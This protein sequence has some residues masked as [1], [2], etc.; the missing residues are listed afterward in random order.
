MIRNKKEEFI[1][2]LTKKTRGDI[3]EWEALSTGKYSGYIF[4]SSRVIKL[5]KTEY[6]DKDILLVEKK[7]PVYNEDYEEYFD[8]SFIEVYVISETGL[9]LIIDDSS[10]SEDLLQ[11]LLR[12]V[13]ERANKISEFIDEF[14]KSK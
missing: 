13:S 2:S 9:E 3:L 5:F 10:A 14:I 12:S 1:S 7:I 6:K 11:N 8:Q 4:D